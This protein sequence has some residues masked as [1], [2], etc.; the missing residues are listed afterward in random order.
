MHRKPFE[1][2]IKSYSLET[3]GRFL[4]RGIRGHLHPRLLRTAS[5]NDSE[6]EV[7]FFDKLVM[8]SKT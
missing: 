2:V 4:K 8:V 5:P 7:F 3:A 1:I 6:E